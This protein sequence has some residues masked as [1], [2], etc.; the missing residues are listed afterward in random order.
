MDFQFNKIRT[1]PRRAFATMKKLQEIFFDYND[2]ETIQE[3]AFLGISNLEFLGLRKNKLK[4]LNVD[5]FPNQIKIKTLLIGAN[6]LNFISTEVLNKISLTTLELD[7]N[8]WKCPCLDRVNFWVYNNNVTLR[9]TKGC[10]TSNLPICV[11]PK[12]FSQ[13]CLEFVDTELTEQYI[14]QLKGI[15][16]IER[17]CL[18]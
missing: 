14:N 7:F 8:P 9:R 16:E 6:R 5:S 10:D 1:I 4:Q 2:I 11:Y 12:S 3:D 15:H 18:E 13:T 17:G